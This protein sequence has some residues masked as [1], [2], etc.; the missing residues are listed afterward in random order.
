M[1]ISRRHKKYYY[2]THTDSTDR[3]RRA[4]THTHTHTACQHIPLDP[5][6]PAQHRLVDALPRAGPRLVVPPHVPLTEMITSQHPNSP[7]YTVTT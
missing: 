2:Y 1:Y 5:G 7:Q 6:L 4:R 3:H